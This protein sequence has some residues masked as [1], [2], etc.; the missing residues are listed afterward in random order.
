M[1]ITKGCKVRCMD[2]EY[3]DSLVQGKKYI[4]TN[5]SSAVGMISIKL[6]DG[7]RGSF[8]KS[9]FRLVETNSLN[10]YLLL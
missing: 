7:T 1:R 4:V 5:A 2:A 9:R 8:F 6:T 10:K 3:T